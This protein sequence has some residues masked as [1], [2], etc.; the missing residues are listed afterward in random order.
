MK[1]YTIVAKGLKLKVRKFWSLILTF[2]EVT[3]ERLVGGPN[4][5][6]SVIFSPKEMQ[7]EQNDVVESPKAKRFYSDKEYF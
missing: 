4:H 3:G 1:F 2:V 5:S 6:K 7:K